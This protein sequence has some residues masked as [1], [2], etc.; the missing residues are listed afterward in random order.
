MTA[1]NT[2][3]TKIPTKLSKLISVTN[4]RRLLTYTLITTCTFYIGSLDRSI[5]TN[6]N[7][8]DIFENYFLLKFIGI[9][10]V[11]RFVFYEFVEYFL[12]LL[13]HGYIKDRILKVRNDL[14]SQGKHS[15]LKG[16]SILYGIFSTF[17]KDYVYR[18]GF[19]TKKD[20]SE[21]WEVTDADKEELLNEMLGDC[22]KWICVTIHLFFTLFFI[23]QYI[24]IWVI[25]GGILSL[26]VFFILPIGAIILVMNIDLI[27]KVRLDILKSKSI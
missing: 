1:D 26:I 4:F 20:L 13:F 11:I 19:L 2:W 8:N 25:I 27:N 18:L 21:E 17:F 12:R 7:I 14:M 15:Y 23:W 9:S 24:N 5:F 10:I 22:Y 16:M 6:R 3:M